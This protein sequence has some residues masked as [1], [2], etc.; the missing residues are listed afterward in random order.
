VANLTTVS[1]V[2]LLGVARTTFGFSTGTGPPTC[3]GDLVSGQVICS[4]LS[5]AAFSV[6]RNGGAPVALATQPEAAGSSVFIGA[7][8]VPGLTAGDT[9]TL[10]E[11]SP[12]AT[13]RHL[14]TLHLY[15][16]RLDIGPG[17]ISGACQPNKQFLLGPATPPTFPASAPLCPTT[18]AFTAAM[19]T[20]NRLFDD[21]SG[22]STVVNVP[23]LADLIPAPDDSIAGGSFTAYADL[24]SVGSTAQALAATRSVNLQIVPRGSAATSFAHDMTPGSD[25]V[26]PFE[27]VAVTGLTTG[28]YDAHWLLTDVNGDTNAFG[29]SFAVQPADTGPT[30]PVGPQGSPGPQGALGPEGGPGPQGTT[31]PRGT[32]GSQGATGSQGPAGPQ[33]AVGPPGPAGRDGISTEVRCLVRHTKK[34]SGK[35]AKSVLVCTVKVLALG[36]H[37]ATVELSRRATTFA[38]GRGA[39]RAGVARIRLHALR[40]LGHG[41]YLVTVVSDRAGRAVVTRSRVA[42]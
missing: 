2:G 24:E 4:N 13:A 15:T 1:D 32:A 38:V 8:F 26:G 9:V 18:G 7:A 21:L 30:G 27:S 3:S 25:A 14:T 6:S 37:L 29:T 5:G 19:P 11:T 17:G 40:P 16:L 36:A 22:G 35:P 12:A 39:V 28:R 33:G 34:T 41:D 42:V 31:G 20:S 23:D 10:D